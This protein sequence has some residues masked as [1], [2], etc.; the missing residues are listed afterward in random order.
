MVTVFDEPTWAT[1]PQQP[2][3][4]ANDPTGSL[5]TLVR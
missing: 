1:R 2:D 4:Q 3:L 5:R